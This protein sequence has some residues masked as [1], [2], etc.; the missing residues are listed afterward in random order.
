MQLK[1]FVADI[2][3]LNVEPQFSLACI[4]EVKSIAEVPAHVISRLQYFRRHPRVSYCLLLPLEP[5]DQFQALY[6][7]LS[8]LASILVVKLR[9]ALYNTQLVKQLLYFSN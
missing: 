6:E 9:G 8:V 2:N 5:V 4:A 1:G 7:L 3:Q